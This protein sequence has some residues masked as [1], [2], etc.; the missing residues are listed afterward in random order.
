MKKTVG[1]LNILGLMA[2]LAV[3]ITPACHEATAATAA[4]VTAHAVSRFI[5]SGKDIPG[6]V[7]ER[8][9]LY[10]EPQN[11]WSYIDGGALPY[12]SYGVREMTTFAA[13]CAPDTLKLVVD[14]Y[15]M[16][17]SFGAFGIYSA[18]RDYGARFLNIGVEGYIAESALFF[19]KDRVYVKIV[20]AA[21]GGNAPPSLETMARAIERRINGGGGMPRLLSLFPTQERV[22][23]SEKYIAKDVLGQDF[24]KKALT[25]DY[26]HGDVP[27]YLFLIESADSVQA[28][29]NFRGY[30]E[31]IRES[32]GIDNPGVRLG[33]EAFSGKESYYGPVLFARKGKFLLVSLGLADPALARKLLASMIDRLQG[34][35]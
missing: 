9:P 18:E 33:D 6:F 34:G 31:F 30:G 20:A 23:R 25:V 5:P 2:C 22:A 26:M 7:I 29:E 13:V 24:L 14:I 10:Y 19:W 12:L 32:G 28:K 1:T 16:G 3:S 8:G 27:Y 17:D 15:D 35:R 4:D 11:L 21:S